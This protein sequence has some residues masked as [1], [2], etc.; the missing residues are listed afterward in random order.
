[1]AAALPKGDEARRQ[2]GLERPVDYA[3]RLQSIFF[4]V[5]FSLACFFL[6][7]AAAAYF[8]LR[9]GFAAPLQDT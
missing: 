7:K 8:K 2:G 3:E 9:G 6:G 1:M 5:S 4:V